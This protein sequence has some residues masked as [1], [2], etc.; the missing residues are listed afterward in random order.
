MERLHHWRMRANPGDRLQGLAKMTYESERDAKEAAHFLAGNA[1]SGDA[2]SVQGAYQKV[3]AWASES[4]ETVPPALFGAILGR[5]FDMATG[6]RREGASQ[7]LD[8]AAL[9]DP[10]VPPVQPCGNPPC[11]LP[12]SLAD[13]PAK[14]FRNKNKSVNNSQ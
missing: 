5:N 10:S 2:E 13:I 11:S 9:L 8:L 1:R 4:G 3:L 12:T 6:A 7:P 14:V